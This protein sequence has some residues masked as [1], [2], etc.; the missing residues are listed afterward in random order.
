MANIEKLTFDEDSANFYAWIEIDEASTDFAGV[1]IYLSVR[2]EV[3][4]QFGEDDMVAGDLELS[5][6]KLQFTDDQYINLSAN[7]SLYWNIC[8]NDNVKQ[9][10]FDS[11]YIELQNARRDNEVD[12]ESDRG[13]YLYEQ[14]KQSLIDSGDWRKGE[15]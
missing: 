13:D 3:D 4:V 10:I 8:D 15:R 9:D 11:A 6:I 14:H 5:A 12:A 2:V 1:G 7:D